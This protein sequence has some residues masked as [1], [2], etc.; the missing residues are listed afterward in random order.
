MWC[1]SKAE[2]S[3][4]FCQICIY[5]SKFV[6]W[7][8]NRLTTFPCDGWKSCSLSGSSSDT[9]GYLKQGLLS[10]KAVYCRIT[11]LSVPGSFVSTHVSLWPLTKNVYW[12]KSVN[13]EVTQSDWSQ[14]IVQL[15][16]KNQTNPPRTHKGKGDGC[17][18]FARGWCCSVPACREL[19][20]LKWS[21]SQMS[22]HSIK[23]KSSGYYAVIVRTRKLGT[24]PLL[25]T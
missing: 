21:W 20:L 16:C 2:E 14:P 25:M 23:I 4:P 1:G 5:C 3:E 24:A 13:Q 18:S 11:C 9:F 6:D 7:L 17:C 12:H 8:N 19:V 10:T 15:S 22:F